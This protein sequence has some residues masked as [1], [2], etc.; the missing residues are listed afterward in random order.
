M[1]LAEAF[2]RVAGPQTR[3]RFEAYDGSA[4]GPQDPAVIVRV[5]SPRA[6][7]LVAGAPG[8]LP[9]AVTVMPASPGSALRAAAICATD[10]LPAR[11]YVRLPFTVS[12]NV[13]PIVFSI[14]STAEPAGVSVKFGGTL[15][16]KTLPT[17]PL[18]RPW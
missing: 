11:S 3:V 7:R 14:R 13:P 15:R 2:E 5:R 6:L 18:S 17:V 8:T 9:T 16:L 1:K 4:A 10:A 12:V